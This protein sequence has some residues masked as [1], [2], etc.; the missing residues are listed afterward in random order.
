MGAVPRAWAAWVGFQE[1]RFR[2]AAWLAIPG[3]VLWAA[4][5][6]GAWIQS[7]EGKWQ[8]NDYLSVG[9]S[10]ITADSLL[11]MLAC[12]FLLIAGLLTVGAIYLLRGNMFGRYLLLAGAWLVVIGQ[13]FAGMLAAIP[14]DAFYYSAPANVV[15]VTPL[16]IFP[17]LVIV[18]LMPGAQLPA[19]LATGS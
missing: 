14:I 12:A 6:L 11:T 5:A 16:A 8:D 4:Q 9:G 1:T 17:V 2:I 3:A 7:Q 19:A 13:L 10:T 15:F 18:C